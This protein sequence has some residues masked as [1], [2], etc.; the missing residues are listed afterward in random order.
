MNKIKKIVVGILGTLVLAIPEKSE[1]EKEQE[2]IMTYWT[3]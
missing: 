2:V 1:Q 3:A